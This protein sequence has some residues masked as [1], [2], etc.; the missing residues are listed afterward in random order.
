MKPSIKAL[1]VEA[2]RSGKFKQGQG[3]LKSERESSR[4]RPRQPKFCC[5]GV[6]REISPVPLKAQGEDDAYLNDAS[7]KKVGLTTANQALLAD[8]N[9]RDG[10]FGE[11]R[12]SFLEIADYIEEYL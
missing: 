2:L 6:L 12:K 7:L 9:D 1:W 11:K 8:M 5:L 3:K 10:D 4:G